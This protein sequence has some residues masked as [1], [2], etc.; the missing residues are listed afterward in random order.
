MCSS[1]Q[2]QQDRNSGCTTDGQSD[3]APASIEGQD[4]AGQEADQRGAASKAAALEEL[5]ELCEGLGRHAVVGLCRLYAENYGTWGGGLPDLL[6]WRRCQRSKGTHVHATL[7]GA[8]RDADYHEGERQRE[9]E[10][11]TD[12]TWEVR[13]VEVKGPGDSLSHRQRAWIDRLVGWGVSVCVC[14]VVA[15]EDSRQAAGQ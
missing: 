12:T 15:V 5:I 3:G 11:G 8:E 2:A 4:T 14:H 9:A 6:L 1:A 7:S 13:L 10:R